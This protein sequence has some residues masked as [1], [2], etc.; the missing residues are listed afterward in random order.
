[1]FFRCA[2]LASVVACTIAAQTLVD[3]RTQSKSVDFSAASTTKPMKTGTVLP[4][5]CGVGE[6]FF[7]TTAPAGSNFYLCT[8]QNS[9]ALQS[10][11]G[12]AGPTGPTG[13]TGATGPTGPTGANGAIAHIQS[14]GTTLPVESTLNFSGG[15]CA[16]D[17]TNSRTDCTGAGI[18]GLSIDVNGAAQGTQS[19]LNLISGTGIIEAC[20]NN[21][22]ANRVDCTPSLDTAYAPSRTLDQAGTDHSIIATSG[23]AGAAFVASG[24]PTFATYTQNQT[25]SFIATD[26]ACVAS[27]TLNIDGLGPIPL[28]KIIGGA[29]V[30]IEAGDCVQ[31]VPILLRASGSPVSAFVLSPDGSPATDWVSN[32]TAQSAS[33]AATTLAS[34]PTAGSFRLTYYL[35]QNGTCTSGSNTVS[36]SFNWT[37]GSNARVLATSSLN[38]G[39]TQSTSGYLSGTLPIYVGSGNVTYSSTVTGSCTTGAS[40]YDVHISLERVQ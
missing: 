25:L 7:D 14:G 34:A 27:A 16:D 20:A 32:L 28:K 38:L 13:A 26:H 3:L 21:T 8:T 23:G 33:Q 36:L 40:S 17:P 4:A 30:G 6:A 12:T 22:G 18:S 11:S 24:S 2:V 9:W 35:D 29:L 19:T 15:G 5:A 39:S 31:N 37:D 10:G 1:M